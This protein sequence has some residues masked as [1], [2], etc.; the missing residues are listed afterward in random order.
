MHV[1]A[2]LSCGS[3]SL[4]KLLSGD[5][6]ETHERVVDWSCVE[7][8]TIKRFLTSCYT[9]DYL[10]P[11]P[12]TVP[13][14]D[15]DEKE[16]SDEESKKSKDQTTQ[17]EHPLL[18]QDEVVD[19]SGPRPLTPMGDCYEEPSKR[20]TTGAGRFEEVSLLCISGLVKVS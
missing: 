8:E 20:I 11:D 7:V 1:E 9:Q 17:K 14:D 5:W 19:A 16:H 6:K 12:T 10:A 13:L 18:A 4:Q 3:L 2:I 15:S